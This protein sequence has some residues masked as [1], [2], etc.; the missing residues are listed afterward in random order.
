MHGMAAKE[1][2][3][4]GTDPEALIPACVVWL[5]RRDHIDKRAIVDRPFMAMLQSAQ[6][7]PAIK[8]S[9]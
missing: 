3:G 9:L 8:I 5:K 2:I 4:C 7:Y 6:R 1:E